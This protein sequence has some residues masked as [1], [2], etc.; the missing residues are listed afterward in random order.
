M[1][2]FSGVCSGHYLLASLDSPC[3]LERERRRHRWHPSENNVTPSA[4]YSWQ[5]L[6]YSMDAFRAFGHF[7][8]S[9]IS[10]YSSIHAHPL[11]FLVSSPVLP[12]LTAI[13]SPDQ[14]GV[15]TTHIHGAPYT[16]GLLPFLGHSLHWRWRRCWRCRVRV[17]N[18]CCLRSNLSRRLFSFSPLSPTR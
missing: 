12:M 1:L 3:N 16:S 9:L 11:T 14:N 5:T 8:S 13:F 2:K 15:Y 17:P 4:R 6:L 18:R 10:T 7:S